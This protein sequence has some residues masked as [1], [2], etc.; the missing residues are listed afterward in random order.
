MCGTWPHA[1]FPLQAGPVGSVPPQHQQEDQS[2]LYS[3]R[4]EVPFL[5]LP[6]IFLDIAT[7]LKAFLG[8]EN[9]LGVAALSRDPGALTPG[10]SIQYW[11]ALPLAPT[12]FSRF[13]LSPYLKKMVFFFSL[14][15]ILERG[16]G[17]EKERERNIDPLPPAHALT[18][19]RNCDPLIYR[20]TPNQLSHTNQGSHY[21]V[22]WKSFSLSPSW[23]K[24]SKTWEL[25]G[26]S[27]FWP[28]APARHTLGSIS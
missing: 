24:P 12:Q 13:T 17:R 22:I 26:I 1:G 11:L 7:R 20:P 25:L 27:V 2:A 9:Y 14:L 3:L 4:L 19:N 23:S 21:F 18:R 10:L 8:D 15:L 6:G 28:G 5:P 16:G